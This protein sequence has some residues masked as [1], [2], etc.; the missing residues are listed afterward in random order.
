MKAVNYSIVLQFKNCQKG[1]LNVGVKQDVPNFGY[2][3]AKTNTYQGM[4]IDLAK[5]IAKELKV[6]VN[7]TAVTPQTREALMD[8]GTIDMLI[9]TYTITDERKASYAMSTPYYY[10]QIG[11]LVQTKSGYKNFLT[12]TVKLLECLKGHLLKLLLKSTLQL[13]TLSL[14]TFNLDLILS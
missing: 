10:D 9:A 11:F 3:S 14:T 1:T 2:Y 5:K 4:E 7:F 6:K 12:L 8:N 13:I